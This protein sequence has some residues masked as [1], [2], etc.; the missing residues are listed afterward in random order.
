MGSAGGT[1]GEVLVSRR[2]RRFVGRE[3]EI[4]R[5][6]AAFAGSESAISVL[7]VH[8]P[9]GIGKSS[10][11]DVFAD[12]AGEAG[13]RVVRL[14]GREL[15]PT[16]GAVLE[17]LG[18]IPGIGGEAEL[19]EHD[20][21]RL[22]LV[23][24]G[25]E[26]LAALDGWVRDDLLPR[27]PSSA[28]TV[29]AA[30]HPPDAAWRADSGWR[31][32]LEVVSLRNLSGSHSR[33]Y[34]ARCG[35][36]PGLHDRVVRATH[37]HPLGLSLL[38][39]VVMRGGGQAVDPLPPDVVGA[40]VERFVDAVPDERQRRALAVCALARRTTEALLR[41]ALG[42]KQARDAF[43]W[44]RELSVVEP[45]PEGLAPHDLARDALDADLRWRD[46][47]GYRV[48]F[49]RVRAHLARSVRDA[50]GREQQRAVFDLKFLF[51][52]LPSVLSPVDWD[53]W[54][55]HYPEP[56]CAAD[57]EAIAELAQAAE[58]E[59]STALV[60][61]W[62]ARQPEGFWVVRAEDG[63][64][65]G[66]LGLL[67]LTAAADEDIAA[68]PGARA[69]W[70]FAHRHVPPRPG[71]T[72]TQTRFI[73]DRDAY[74]GPSP[75]L[76][77]TPAVT[78]PRK[79]DTPHLSWDFLTLHEPEPWDDYFALADVPRAQGADFEVAGRP[80]GLYAHDY[81]RVPIDD[82][83]ELWTERALAK[84]A[85]PT[86]APARDPDALLLAED[87]FADAVRQTLRDLH[88]PDLLARNP[89]LRT[90]L[91]RDH[92]GAHPDAAA[93]ERLLREAVDELRR[94]PRD[95]KLLRAVEATYLRPAA[96]QEAAAAALRLPFSTYRRHLARGFSRICEWLWD[97]EIS[98]ADRAVLRPRASAGPRAS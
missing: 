17:A 80:Y 79:L 97:R 47:D 89:L 5:F 27:L 42:D 6:C 10:L 40:L 83:M 81:R 55:L 62:L 16:P 84:E 29:I 51:R 91:L 45:G 1:L 26:Q 4:E 75:T 59:A 93:L 32:L 85:A 61:R 96:T 31:E 20:D 25:Y 35:V 56:A 52:N 15:A 54:G 28:L 33:E 38:A 72:V 34:L 65:R 66:F 90:R 2:R 18:E 50:R 11:L 74:Q 39:D 24:D 87:E 43:E 92:A 41:A 48:V 82:L 95:D 21:D 64:V 58:G 73:V 13:G 76:N 70:D 49:R 12:W 19:G 63:S 78:I 57:H 14:D 60:R 22:V 23:I 71:E 88:R 44:L 53:Q 7:Y 30:R 9:G 46:P 94:H 69:A 77:A 3:D 98:G 37:G 36:D 67:D 8:G 68:D 86:P